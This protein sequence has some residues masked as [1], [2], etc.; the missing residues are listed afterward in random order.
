M[1]ESNR[2]PNPA[3]LHVETPCPKQWAELVGGDAKRYCSQCELHVHN[4]EELTKKEAEA[5]VQ[6]SAER[7]CMRIVA[8]PDGQPIFKAEPAVA[9]NSDWIPGLAPDELPN[10][11]PMRAIGLALAAGGLIAACQP[12]QDRPA[13][14]YRPTPVETSETGGGTPQDPAPDHPEWMGEVEIMGIV[15]PNPP[16]PEEPEGPTPPATPSDPAPPIDQG[17]ELMGK[18][19][20]PAPTPEP[21][22]KLGEVV[23]PTDPPV[24]PESPSTPQGPDP[25]ALNPPLSEPTHVIMGRVIPVNASPKEVQKV[26]E[27]PKRNDA[28]SEC[29]G[30]SDSNRPS[31]E[32]PKD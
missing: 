7:V 30:T 1:T 18:V 31:A 20:L 22:E 5:L 25:S 14:D 17:P 28:D 15:A 32:K 12:N 2:Q 29:E 19:A 10:R 4:S 16:N 21:L 3:H 9:A 23:A 13:P 11:H 26:F 27:L 24:V 6:Q 8:D